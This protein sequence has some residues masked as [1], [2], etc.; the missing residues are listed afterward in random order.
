MGSGEQIVA[1]MSKNVVF[2]TG[3]SG[4]LYGAPSAHYYMWDG[5]KLL[6]ATW[7]ERVA[8]DLF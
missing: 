1:L 6:V 4:R 3:Y 7:D 2:R 8:A 5:E